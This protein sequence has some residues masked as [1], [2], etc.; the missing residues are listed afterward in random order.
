MRGINKLL[1]FIAVTLCF[2]GGAAT[3]SFI[4]MGLSVAIALIALIL[5][6]YDLPEKLR[7]GPRV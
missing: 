5:D 6:I 1:T 2:F 4:L 7:K 3:N